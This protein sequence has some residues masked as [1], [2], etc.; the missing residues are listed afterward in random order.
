M[1]YKTVIY[2][3]EDGIAIVQ[4]NR[5]EALNAIN[6]E[7]LSELILVLDDIA[8]DDNVR[9]I[10][11]KGTQTAFAAGADIK[12][13]VNYSPQEAHKYIELVQICMNK[14]VNMKK[15][16]IASIAGYALGGGCELA[17]ASDIRIAA[18]NA[19]FGL[20]EISLGVIP[21]G[22]GTQRLTRL[23]GECKAKELILFGSIIDAKR[24]LEYGMLNRMVALDKLDETSTKW[25]KKL[26]EKPPIA[27]HIVKELI[28]LSYDT[29]I[30]TGL[31]MEK[32][33]FSFL[34]STRDQ[35][36]GMNAF[37][38]GRTANFVGA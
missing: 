23:V 16:S 14:F 27:M 33:K 17:L 18:D 9:V 12:S 29:D 38:E 35:K 2:T 15:P 32:E 3:K 10:L 5:P 1:E 4:L 19:L 31:M 7:L 20:P 26:C 25:A 11:I 21:G 6:E 34:F 22:S 30:S 13:L 24:A 36:E 28:G 8:V 37:L